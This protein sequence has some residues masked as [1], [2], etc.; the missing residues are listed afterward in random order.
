MKW[1]VGC[2]SSASRAGCLLRQV[3]LYAMMV[4]W[5]VQVIDTVAFSTRSVSTAFRFP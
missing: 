2:A 4:V 3:H 1:Q 5:R